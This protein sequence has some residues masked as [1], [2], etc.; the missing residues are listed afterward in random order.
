MIEDC[1][2][3]VPAEQKDSIFDRFQDVGSTTPSRTGG[4]GLSLAV[5]KA[6]V[7]AHGGTLTVEASPSNRFQFLL[8]IPPPRA[9]TTA[10]PG[11]SESY[12]PDF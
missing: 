8:E 11:S 9:K 4:V 2:P 5:C 12:E 3:L 6:L 10:R 1:G 7:L